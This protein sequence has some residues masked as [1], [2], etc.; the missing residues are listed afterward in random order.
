MITELSKESDELKAAA[1][2]FDVK[3]LPKGFI[4]DPFPL[5]HA[6]RTHDP[7]HR[8][9]DGSL[10][11]TRHQDLENVYKDTTTFSSD[12]KIEFGA[13]YGATPLFDHHTTSLVFNDPPLHTRVRKIL[14]GALNPR[15]V[16][17]L[18]PAVETLV[19]RLL[20]AMEEK[21]DVDLI[22]DFACA[23]PVEVI[24]NLLDVPHDERGPLRDW[25][26][27]ILGALEPVLTP[28]QTERGNRAVRE[29][30]AYLETLVAR[31]REKPGDPEHDV[32]TRL[33]RGEQDG[34]K[35]SEAELLQNCIFILNAGHETTTNLIGNALWLF[36]QWPDQRARIIADP[37]L[38][39]LAVEEALRIESSNQLG[40]RL[41]T[42]DTEI[43]GV[44]V[45]RGSFVT[46]CIGA[47]NRDP[48][49]FAE[50]DR[51]DIGRQPNRHLGY[52][53]GPHVCV[54]M[55]VARLEGRIAVS[56]FLARFP[57]YRLTGNA[58][59]SQRI[60]FRGFQS[61]PARVA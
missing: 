53:S 45:S 37:S 40:N 43:G 58:V 51:F 50:P 21:G 55:S 4:D 49:V 10:F 35:L 39:R 61:L 6:L 31:R 34:S 25:S 23:I 9:P 8:M 17:A 46:L 11:L 33:I 16:S 29:F 18:E 41:T 60:R 28:E 56:R 3:A 32:L 36:E 44:P 47:A 27:A 48:A 26:L 7:V 15:A 30:L 22:E 1:L 57:N 54:G 12:K 52:A 24:G 38:A 19:G 20:D 59:R 2:A 42:A 13:K 5:Y 14:A